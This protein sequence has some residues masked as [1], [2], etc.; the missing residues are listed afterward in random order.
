MVSSKKRKKIHLKNS[1]VPNGS[2][3]F[4]ISKGN[5]STTV[6]TS[7]TKRRVLRELWITTQLRKQ[8]ISNTLTRTRLQVTL[9]GLSQSAGVA[10][11]L[12]SLLLTVSTCHWTGRPGCP[13]IRLL[14]CGEERKRQAC[15]L[16]IC[17]PFHVDED[18]FSAAFIIFYQD[19]STM[20]FIYFR[21]IREI[22]SWIHNESL[23]FTLQ[24]QELFIMLS[25][26]DY[27][28]YMYCN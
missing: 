23:E 16:N 9:W 21:T 25:G 8:N 15:S 24:L 20:S 11:G 3:P 5:G 19:Q 10:T 12:G 18:L 13:L 6:L 14:L 4:S 2:V 26:T 22:M 7:P 27:N 17:V 28:Y 1:P